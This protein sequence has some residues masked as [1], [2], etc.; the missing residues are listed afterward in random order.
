MVSGVL[1]DQ[2]KPQ[3]V[4]SEFKFRFSSESQLYKQEIWN[5]LLG[6]SESFWTVAYA[7]SSSMNYGDPLVFVEILRWFCME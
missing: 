1:K 7:Q 4:N 2:K 6:S 3:K 5:W